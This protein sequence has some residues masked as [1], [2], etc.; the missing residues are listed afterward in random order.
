MIETQNSY[1]RTYSSVV[2]TIQ[3]GNT[4]SNI[5]ETGGM[6]ILRVCT[7]SNWLASVMSFN[8]SE[9]G[10]SVLRAQNNYDGSN[11]ALLT[12]PSVNPLDSIPLYA[13]WFGSSYYVQV[14]SSVTQT[15]TTNVLLI[16]EPL[17]QGIHG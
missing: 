17:W 15:T 1:K 5:V 10:S 13:H 11:K 7:D 3:A 8:V 16:L 2:A 9:D 6:T 4:A 12:I 14:V